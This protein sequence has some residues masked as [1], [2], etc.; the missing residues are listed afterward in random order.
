MSSCPKAVLF[1]CIKTEWLAAA[2]LR[3]IGTNQSQYQWWR[4]APVVLTPEMGLHKIV[5]P[6]SARRSSHGSCV[7]V[8]QRTERLPSKQ[9][10]EANSV[11]SVNNLHLLNSL[12]EDRKAT[13]GLTAGGERW[14]RET[15]SKFLTWLPV[16]TTQVTRTHIV[17]FLG[18]YEA[19]PW[20]K[21]SMYRALRAFW[22]WVST[23]YDV[24]NPMMDHRGNSVI[25][26][27]KTPS[28][29]LYTMTPEKV[30]SLLD[31]TLCVS[32]NP[33][34]DDFGDSP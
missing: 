3:L 23:T 4:I 18:Q 31:A 30:H 15:L 13:R 12:I 28:K 9:S 24:P 33:P 22:R 27:P 5:V 2:P 1:G 8:A 21:H 16:P 34:K 11:N 29:V 6:V 26:A 32:P 20:R 25:E 10:R 7:P 17:S 19:K 14:L